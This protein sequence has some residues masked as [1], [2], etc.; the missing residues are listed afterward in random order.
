MYAWVGLTPVRYTSVAKQQCDCLLSSLPDDLVEAIFELLPKMAVPNYGCT[1]V[2]YTFGGHFDGIEQLA[3]GRNGNVWI[4]DTYNHRVHERHPSTGEA[5]SII[6]GVE[7]REPGEFTFPSGVAVMH[8]GDSFFVLDSDSNRI[9]QHNLRGGRFK[10]TLPEVPGLPW[11]EANLSSICVSPDETMLAVSDHANH[12]VVLLRLDGSQPALSLGRQG[13]GDGEFQRPMDVRFTPDGLRVVVADTFN[14][15]IQVMTLDDK[16]VFKIDCGEPVRAVAVDGDGNIL[17]ATVDHVK[18]FS[19]EGVLMQD[20][21]GGL[22]ME[23]R[24]GN[25]GLAID[26]GSGRIAVAASNHASHTVYMLG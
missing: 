20:K 16:F 2:K 18:V 3:F 7:G 12:R 15:R 17:A 5:V 21:L 13:E 23:N 25:C 11:R 8:K 9:C 19:S 6:G 14:K 24:L 22:E 26:P 10:R 1:S 4:V